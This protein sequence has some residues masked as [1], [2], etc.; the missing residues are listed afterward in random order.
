MRKPA[1]VLLLSVAS[2]AVFAQRSFDIDI[3]TETFGYNDDST[4]SVALEDLNQGCS[5][6]DCIPSIDDPE[7]VT[8]ATADFIDDDDVVIALSWKGEQRA[9]PARILDHHEIVND[10]IAGTALAI[11]W[12]PLCGSAVGVHREIDGQITEFGVSGLLYNSDLVFYDRA[13]NTLWDQVIAEGIVGPLTGTKLELFPVTM[14]TWGR[15]RKEHPDTLVLSTNTGFDYDYSVD[16]Y[17]KYRDSTKLMFPVL[18]TDDRVRPKTVVF[19][20]DLGDTTVAFTEALLTEQKSVSYEPDDRE[21]LVTMGDD[22]FVVL[23]TEDG[24]SHAPIR[25]FWFA[26]FTFHPQTELVK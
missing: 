2:G 8:A 7:Y 3:L 23:K 20:F 25:L 21:M 26:W 11:T 18:Q 17:A 22:G 6:R 4:K 13:T 5:R 12:C 14:T 1:I 10:T 16:P 19:G 9:Y 15:W 24:E